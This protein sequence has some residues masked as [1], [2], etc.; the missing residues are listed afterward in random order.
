[1][2]F[3]E[4]ADFNTHI[5]DE[6]INGIDRDQES[7]L[8]FAI[9]AAQDEIQA[10]R[11]SQIN[12]QFTAEVV[13]SFIKRLIKDIAA[14]HFSS[15]ASGSL[16]TQVWLTKYE[17][18]ISMLEYLR[19]EEIDLAQK[20]IENSLRGEEVSYQFPGSSR[21]GSQDDLDD[22]KAELAKV[23]KELLALELARKE[24]PKIE[25]VGTSDRRELR[26]L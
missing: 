3:V 1:M 19:K 6:I 22:A 25:V 17:N 20:A 14:F 21:S 9:E 10:F 7:L 12:A 4:I 2:R 18:C 8:N 24:N 5:Y 16:N 23:Q 11:I 26:G 15:L 13:D